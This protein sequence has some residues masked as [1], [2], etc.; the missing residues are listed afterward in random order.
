MELSEK[1]KETMFEFY[2]FPENKIVCWLGLDCQIQTASVGC[3]NPTGAVG[4]IIFLEKPKVYDFS[5][6]Y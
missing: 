1:D 2:E 6:F 5:R 4:R 3:G